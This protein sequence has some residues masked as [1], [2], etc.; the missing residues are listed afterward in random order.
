MAAGRGTRFGGDKLLYPVAGIPLAERAFSALPPDIPG[1]VVTGDDRIAVLAEAHPNLSVL[2]TGDT[3]H[4]VAL[5]IRTGTEALPAEA[6]GAVYM[7]CD[8]PWLT[9]ES[10]QKL[11]D[12]FQTAPEFIYVLSDRDRPGNPCLFPR[13][14][15]PELCRLPAHRGG[16]A[17]IRKY[18]DQVRRIPANAPEE[19]EDMDERP[20]FS[21]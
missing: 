3:A 14:F 21:P 12:A 5:T 15:F 18:P 9:R 16:K 19:L 7:V 2:L 13:R 20:S 10:V 1:I 17:L 8:Q 6:D 4:D 11:L